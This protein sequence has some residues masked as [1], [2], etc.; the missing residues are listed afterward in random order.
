MTTVT[1][2]EIVKILYAHGHSQYHPALA[3]AL[4]DYFEAKIQ[5][6]KDEQEALDVSKTLWLEFYGAIKTR[7]L[8]A[9]DVLSKAIQ[10]IKH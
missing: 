9:V 4:E 3:N 10:R 2:N 8:E 6:V 5:Q 7:D 1:N